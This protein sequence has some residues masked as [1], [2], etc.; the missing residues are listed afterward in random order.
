VLLPLFEHGLRQFA[1]FDSLC[2]HFL[3]SCGEVAVSSGGSQWCKQKLCPPR[4]L[5]LAV[6]FWSWCRTL[7]SLWAAFSLDRLSVEILGIEVR[8]G[9]ENFDHS[10]P[11]TPSAL[12]AFFTLP[13]LIA[14]DKS[15]TSTS[16]SV[17]NSG[18]ARGWFTFGLLRLRFPHNFFI[19]RGCHCSNH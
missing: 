10:A 7:S 5:T 4:T 18:R 14:F 13:F 3:P 6:S 8:Y 11:R 1:A 12:S 9:G 15:P 19:M 2:L 16:I 17:V